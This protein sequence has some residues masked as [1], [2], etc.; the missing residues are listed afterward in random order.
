MMDSSSSKFPLEADAG[1]FRLI[2]TSRLM[3]DYF[4]SLDDSANPNSSDPR[5]RAITKFQELLLI[6]F[7]EFAIITE[8]TILSERRRFR[9]EVISSLESF[10]KRSAIRNLKS[11]ERFNKEQ[12]GFIYDA[13]FKAV[14]VEPP[15]PT[16][17]PSQVTLVTTKDAAEERPETRVGLKTFKVFLSEI[18]TWAR[19]EKVVMNGFQVHLTSSATVRI[20]ELTCL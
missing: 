9:N 16:P 17:V 7:R 8:E 20:L 2:A 4:C 3:R 12:V 6:S 10:S 11:L 15:P 1:Y 5:A 19:E 14:C 18:A 13:L